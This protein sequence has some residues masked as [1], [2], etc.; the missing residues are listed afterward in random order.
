[1][2][3]RGKKIRETFLKKYGVEHPSQLISVKEK[4]KKKREEGAYDNMIVNMKKTLKEKY[5]DENYNN[6]EKGKET[7]LLIYGDENYNNREKMLETNQRKYGMSVSPNVIK[8][9]TKRAQSGEIGFKS[10]KYQTFL[11]EN[12][13]D[14]ISQMASVKIKKKENQRKLYL[15]KLFYGDRLKSIVKPLFTENEYKDTEY[16]T[17]YKFECCKCKNIFEDTLYSGNIPRCLVCYPYNRFKSQIELDIIDFLKSVGI[18]CKQHDRSVL[19]GEEIDILINDK[20][21]GIEC[22]GIIWHSE[23]FGKKDKQYH[24][25]KSIL[26]ESKGISL[27]HVWD[28]E[29]LNKKELIKSIVLNKI[30]KS[31]KLY[32]RECEIKEITNKQKSEFVETNHIQGNDNGSIR[33]GLFF[34][35]ELVSVMTFI[36]S[37]YDKNYEYEMSRYCNKLNTSIVGGASKLF[38]YFISSYNPKSIVSYCDKRFFN[39]KV[40]TN[41]GMTFVGDTLPSYYY[42]HKNNCVPVNRIKFQK[43][44]LNT[45]LKSFNPSLTEWENMQLNGYDRI[46]DCGHYKYVWENTNKNFKYSVK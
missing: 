25:N 43:H 19:N 17:L 28:W 10:E 8:S 5:G 16:N 29:W 18:Q 11:K 44:K 14:N 31:E 39:G 7:K 27:I 38:S 45:I 32:A 4:I 12:D 15:K 3:E 20:N 36:K 22:D 41:I 33:V 34:N 13:I 21:I 37:R 46:W 9:T 40:Y 2:T 6:L 42:F 35:K 23:L 24:L 26:A 1:M 30:N